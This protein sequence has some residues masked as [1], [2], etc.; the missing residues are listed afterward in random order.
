MLYSKKKVNKA[1]R[2]KKEREI[3]IPGTVWGKTL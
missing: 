3:Q 1:R 2:E